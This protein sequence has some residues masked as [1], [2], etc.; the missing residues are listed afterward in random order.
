MS[1][2]RQPLLRNL[3][4]LLSL[5]RVTIRLSG[6]DAEWWFRVFT[7]RHP[8]YHIIQHKRWGVG[9]LDLPGDFDRFLKAG[10]M[11]MARRK[12]TRALTMGYRVEK[13]RALDYLDDIMTV[14]ES[15][16]ERQGRPMA[17]P[18]FDRDKV[19]SHSEWAG[20]IYAAFDPSGR[21]KG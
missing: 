3:K 19:R 8:R 5:P 6:T 9:L 21:V 2:G 10:E 1:L 7:K 16:A 20:Q 4:E 12:R 14:N 13:V 15:M 17:D 11:R 18:Y